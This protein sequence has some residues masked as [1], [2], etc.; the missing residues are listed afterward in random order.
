MAM[1]SL[2]RV[3]IVL[4]ALAGGALAGDDP[5]SPRVLLEM[6]AF[7]EEH[8]RDL[9]KA[10]GLYKE[11]LI[12]AA[13]AGDAET[14]AEAERGL[15]RVAER[16]DGA[17]PEAP[18][19]GDAAAIENRIYLLVKTLST[20]D[21]AVASGE[22]EREAAVSQLSVFG[23]AAVPE[24]ERALAAEKIL[25]PV[26]RQ[27]Y[28]AGLIGGQVGFAG[29]S[30]WAAKA[31]AAID[32]PEAVAALDRGLDSA[33]PFVRIA[34]AKA[35][36]SDRH[37]PILE[38]AARD[39]V[40]RVR[41]IAIEYLSAVGDP[42]LRPLMEA[43]VREGRYHAVRWLARNAPARVLEIAVD[44]GLPTAARVEAVYHVGE[45]ADL[46]GR[47]RL[48]PV[49]AALE[50]AKD[51]DLAK[52]ACNVLSKI[53][54][55]KAPGTSDEVLHAR[56]EEAA[57]KWLADDQV[58]RLAHGLL[59]RVGG[60]RT[61][62]V[63]VSRG[64]DDIVPAAERLKPEDF[65]RVVEMAKKAP[66]NE[67][68]QWTL[69][70]AL[71]TLAANAAVKPEEILRGREALPDELREGYRRVVV[72]SACDA[73][74]IEPAIRDCLQSPSADIRTRA[75]QKIAESNDAVL[76]LDAV[77]ALL[78][79]PDA[80]IV[81]IA[82]HSFPRLAEKDLTRA[83]D[84]LEKT[85]LPA[86]GDSKGISYQG[87]E[88]LT[89]L[90]TA[91]AVALF[92]RLMTREPAFGLRDALADVFV[93]RMPAG[94]K[95]TAAI[96]AHYASFGAAPVRRSAIVRFG[97]ELYEP[98]VPLLGEALNDPDPDVRANA[99]WAFGQFK[100]HREAREE[101]EAWQTGAKEGEAT[102]AELLTLLESEHRAVV[103]GAVRSLGAL[104]AKAALPA[105]VRLLERQDAEVQKAVEEAIAKIGG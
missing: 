83:V 92:D 37:R 90:P 101:F 93:N 103:L 102:V 25:S 52:T 59:K 66:L 38:R 70:R 30:V 62:E 28:E 63:L 87:L 85:F 1:K 56:M 21:L 36:R 33:D 95:A 32:A 79:D 72:A 2:A 89:R 80:T 64:S 26:E 8:E 60:I 15:T 49:L 23:A 41:N 84:L 27:Q 69:L 74:A 44:E 31:L 48:Q 96:A 6:A 75:L 47:E 53:L 24:L 14:R 61:V 73:R 19:P 34:V 50:D 43:A 71:E 17:A 11:A 35:L 10:A 58:S 104:R 51:P 100:V 39:P 98:A 3:W 4:L 57:L 18:R 78:R 40:E 88:T 67:S 82:S 94:P 22:R 76:F 86:A 16:L 9:E 65:G 91:E 5:V 29:D 105:L 55:K 68:Q 97:K 12:A 99:R 81:T 7:A 20:A 46:S 77:A 45:R 42:A 13:R 54:D